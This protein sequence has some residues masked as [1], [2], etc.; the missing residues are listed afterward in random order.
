MTKQTL[1]RVFNALNNPNRMKIYQI[2][3]KEH[4]N[5]AKLKIRLGISYKSILKNVNILEDSKLV[6]KQKKI[7]KFIYE[8][9]ICSV[10]LKENPFYYKIFKELEKEYSL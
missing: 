3:L 5:M 4:I 8:C 9:K 2:C 7:I 1:S 10:N 6:I